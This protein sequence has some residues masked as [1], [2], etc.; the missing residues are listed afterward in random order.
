MVMERRRSLK[1]RWQ[2]KGEV[3]L[4]K[5]VAQRRWSSEGNGGFTK[6]VGQGYPTLLVAQVRQVFFLTD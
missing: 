6:V 1:K 5:M 2:H 4:R 3:G